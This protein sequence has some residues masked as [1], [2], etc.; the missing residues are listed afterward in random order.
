MTKSFFMS[1]RYNAIEIISK[2]GNLVLDSGTITEL[3]S[4]W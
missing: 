2:G 3:K 1:L 4:I